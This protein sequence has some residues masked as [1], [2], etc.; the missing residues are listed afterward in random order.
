MGFWLDTHGRLCCATTDGSYGDVGRKNEGKEPLPPIKPSDKIIVA[1][2]G[3]LF[4][5][6]LAFFFALLVWGFGKPVRE[7]LQ[8]TVVVSRTRYAC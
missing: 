5:L 3:P 6:G 7:Q 4:S 1:F 2:A 8:S